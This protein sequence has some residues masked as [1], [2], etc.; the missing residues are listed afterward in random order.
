MDKISG[1][2]KE[3]LFVYSYQPQHKRT[4][5]GP[6]FCD[7]ECYDSQPESEV[8]FENLYSQ[9]SD[10]VPTSDIGVE[11]FKSTLVNTCYQ[12]RRSKIGTGICKES[13]RN[14]LK[15]LRQ[16]RDIIISK[17]DKGMGTVLFD[18]TDC[19]TKMYNILDDHSK[20]QKLSS[21]YDST[22]KVEQQLTDMLKSLKINNIITCSQFDNLKPTGSRIPRLY[23]LPKVHKPGVPLRQV[24]DMFGSPYHAVAKWLAEIL[25][26]VHRE[27][28]R[29]SVRDTFDF[30]E[31]IKDKNVNDKTMFSLDVSSLFTNVPLVETVNFICDYITENRFNIGLPVTTLKE[32]ILRCTMNIQFQFNKELFS[33]VDAV[34]MGSPLGPILADIFMA[35][36]ENGKCKE[37]ISKFEVYLRYMDDTFIICDPSI[38]INTIIPNFNSAHDAIQLSHEVEQNNRLSF[39]DV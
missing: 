21:I 4:S 31:R 2:A 25:K 22:D 8:Q 37:F 19:I 3:F 36:L 12:F 18:K 15:R 20:F 38:D 10:L 17:P 29:Y 35:K 13:T 34:A 33:Q 39:L 32:L 24:L 5:L 9:T 14:R 28:T 30:I 16:N 26:P 23:G 11:N 1:R 27:L 7:N 6:R